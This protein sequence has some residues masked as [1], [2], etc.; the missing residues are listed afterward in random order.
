[1]QQGVGEVVDRAWATVTPRLVQAQTSY[2][3][4]STQRSRCSGGAVAPPT[5][6][7]APDSVL[8]CDDF[9]DD[10]A[11]GVAIFHLCHSTPGL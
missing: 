2:N 10:L 5:P 6:V 8:S 1:M 4:P 3:V 7:D 11:A 9:E